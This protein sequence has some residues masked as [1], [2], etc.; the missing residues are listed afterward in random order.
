[1]KV[2]VTGGSGQLGTVVLRRLIADRTIKEIV[3]L[4]LRPPTVASAKVRAVEAD[5]RDPRF[6]RHLAGCDA[7]VHLAF[8]VTRHLPRAE[9][10]AV[11]VGGSKNVFL[12]AAAAGARTIVYASSVAA[13]GSFA[14]NPVPLDEDSPR[15]F[16]RDFAY[17]ACK[18]LVEDFLDAFEREHP[19]LAIARMRPAVLVGARMEHGLGQAWGRRL[20]V[21]AGGAPMPMV[22]DEDAA[23]AFV[24]ALK[25]RARGA[26]TLVAADPLPDP[27]LARAGGL[28]YV[29]VPRRL[30]AGAARLSP[31]LARLGL[32]QPVDPAWLE[33]GADGVFVVTCRRALD[34]LGWR[35]R[36]PTTT[37]VMRRFDREVPHRLD[38][39]LAVFLR[40]TALAARAAPPDPE[41]RGFDARVHVCLTGRNG[42]DFTVAARDGRVRFSPGA[43]RAPTAVLTLPAS[44]FLD[45]LVG[46]TDFA[47]AQFT[48]RIRVEGE[49]MA[50]MILGGIVSRF[51]AA[52]ARPGL[53]GAVAR[54]LAAWLAATPATPAVQ[55][56]TSASPTPGAAPR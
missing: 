54:R 15:R 20:H 14:D 30:L 8:V 17:A 49:G 46:R 47:A 19:D 53:P 31:L 16:Q 1:M 21:S 12:A 55:A 38:P 41:I 6:E 44:T 27:E 4:D 22:W 28:R 45:L 33:G 18:Y 13:Y 40:L 3:S 50:T 25:A 35:P 32:G 51:R 9:Y 24:L 52:A 56:S 5:I 34:E 48:G 7:L 11:N 23:D 36:C 29:R 26:F 37:D 43:P 2:A 39:R 42:G 10:E